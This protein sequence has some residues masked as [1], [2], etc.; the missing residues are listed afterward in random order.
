MRNFR[1]ARITCNELMATHLSF[2]LQLAIITSCAAARESQPTIA[3]LRDLGKA[4]G[5]FIGSAAG[6]SHFQ[7]DS[8]YNLTLGQQFSLV[9]PEN[10][11]KW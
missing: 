1:S 11:C 2:V 9:T 10:A 5:L 4:A 7:N 3:I 8:Q 6:V